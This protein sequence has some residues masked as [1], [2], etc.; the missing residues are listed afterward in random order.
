MNNKQIEHQRI[1]VVFP[2]PDDEAFTAS[3]TLAKYIKGGAQVTYA[4]LTLGEM[5]RNMGIPPFA[6]R[7]TLPIIRK[8]ELIESS[9]AIGIQD[10]RMLGFHDK[11]IEFEDPELLDGHILALIKEL[12]PSLVITFYPG[13]SV[14]PD[15]DATGAAVTRTIG[16]LPAEERPIV[17][18]CAFSNNHEESI[19]KA[20]VIEDVSGFLAE[21]MA[22]IRAH[23][24]QFQAP[25]LVGKRE[26]D[27]EQIR[28]RFGREAFWTYK[29]N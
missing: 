3:G 14:H 23:R 16:R 15:H 8:D 5:G 21:K 12:N 2:H 11:M 25:E 10:L 13:Y 24:S 27:D 4:C 28:N 19:G 7:V 9:N 6:N 17:Y 1:L 22:S 29:F 18:C 20:D 26:L